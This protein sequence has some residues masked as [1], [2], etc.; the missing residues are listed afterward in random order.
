MVG[1]RVA[2]GRLVSVPGMGQFV[3]S[4]I[5]GVGLALLCRRGNYISQAPLQNSLV[6]GG[7]GYRPM[8]SADERE[9]Q[10]EGTVREFPLPFLALL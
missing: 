5:S 8:G 9:G 3:L 6:G 10:E 2:H 1:K 4:S 7:G